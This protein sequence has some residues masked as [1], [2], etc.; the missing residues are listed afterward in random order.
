[1]NTFILLQ[2]A[3]NKSEIMAQR[4]PHGVIMT[5]TSVA[6]VFCALILL[7]F[8]Y[9]LIGNLSSG[10]WDLK[11][12]IPKRPAKKAAK[13]VKGAEGMSDEVAAAIA[14]ALDKELGSETYAAIGMA[15]H[16]YFNDTVHDLES[17]IITIK[18]KKQS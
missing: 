17:Y 12:L 15:L 5:V 8:A 6:V 2:S 4:D 3:L 9:T 14:M 1:M 16:Q 10:R 13:P 7:F 11:K 18:R